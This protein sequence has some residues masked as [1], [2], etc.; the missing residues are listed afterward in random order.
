MAYDPP[1][2]LRGLIDKIKE[3]SDKEN[4]NFKWL[5]LLDEL[6]LKRYRQD[7]SSMDPNDNVEIMVAVNPIIDEKA[8]NVIPPRSEKFVFKRLTFKHRNSLEISIFLLHFKEKMVSLDDLY[9]ASIRHFGLSDLD[10]VALV[11]SA[12]PAVDKVRWVSHAFRL[13]VIISDIKFRNS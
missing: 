8:F 6:V 10:D 13:Q 4:L 5:I 3:K 12:F 2:T 11:E 1:N 9:N 7:F